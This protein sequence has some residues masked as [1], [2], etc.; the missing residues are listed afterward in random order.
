MGRWC[1]NDSLALLFTAL[2]G[3]T[4]CSARLWSPAAGQ[5]QWDAQ[6]KALLLTPGFA[7]EV[8]RSCITLIAGQFS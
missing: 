7:G 3:H 5:G 4:F 2:P 1:Q 8:S 6:T